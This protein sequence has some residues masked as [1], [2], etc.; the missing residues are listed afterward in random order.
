[1]SDHMHDITHHP[2]SD[3]LWLISIT[4]VHFPVMTTDLLE[5]LLAVHPCRWRTPP[6]IGWGRC[7]LKGE[8]QT[9]L[10]NPAQHALLQT[11]SPIAEQGPAATGFTDLGF[12]NMIICQHHLTEQGPAATGLRVL[13]FTI[14]TYQHPSTEQG[15]AATG[16]RLL[17]FTTIII[18]QHLKIVQLLT[19]HSRDRNLNQA[20]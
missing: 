3:P 20:P 14:I 19:G 9:R 1:M 6:S 12:T 2:H 16:F 11:C 18:C 17:G 13:R 15:P 5:Q 8:Q 10:P 4:I 7:H